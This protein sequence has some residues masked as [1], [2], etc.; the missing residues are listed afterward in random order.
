MIPSWLVIGTITFAVAFLI[1]RIP[2]DDRQWFNLLRRPRWLTFEFAIP[3]IWIFIFVCGILSA[4]LIW[5]ASLPTRQRWLLMGIYLLLELAILAYTPVMCKIRSL[6]VGTIIGG[7]GFIIGL[8]LAV[9]VFPINKGASLLLFPYLL[10]SPVGTYVTWQM[11]R[12]NP[13]NA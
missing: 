11:I 2:I 8:I 3:F 5:D 10:W 7:V 13:G 4:S 6:M 12:L 1:N 9:M